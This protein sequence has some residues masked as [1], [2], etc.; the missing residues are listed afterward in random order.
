MT[1]KKASFRK[2]APE[3]GMWWHFTSGEGGR[4]VSFVWRKGPARGA[5]PLGRDARV[6][7]ALGTWTSNRDIAPRQQMAGRW[8]LVQRTL[9]AARPISSELCREY[10]WRSHQPAPLP[11]VCGSA[12]D[13]CT[14]PPVVTKARQA[15]NKRKC[16]DRRS[17]S[18]CS[19]ACPPMTQAGR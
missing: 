7:W 14:C 4:A 17:A 8:C 2:F 13:A 5:G 6:D 18:S 1:D 12:Q 15:K 16:Q 11:P 19:A 10:L 3:A 9:W